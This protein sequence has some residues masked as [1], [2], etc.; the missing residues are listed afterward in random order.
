[1]AIP[2]IPKTNMSVSFA[3]TS[4]IPPDYNAY[5]SSYEEAE[6][7]A[8]TAEAPGSTNTVY[9]FCQILHVLTEDSADLYLILPNRTLK[10]IGSESGGDKSFTFRQAV[11]AER[12]EIRHGLA[13]FPSVTVVDSSGSEV[14]GDVQYID[15][16]Q[17][18]VM[19]S[20]PFSG[21]AYLN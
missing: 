15:E 4:A 18:V 5:F 12:W 8:Q 13:K 17:V 11:A 20:A 16:N 14:M 1:M 19:F 6:A 9:Y 2:S 7:A 10:Y 3:M 21:T